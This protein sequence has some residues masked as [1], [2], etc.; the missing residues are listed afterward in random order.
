MFAVNVEELGTRVNYLR[1]GKQ[2]V[3]GLDRNN[4]RLLSVCSQKRFREL[5]HSE[6]WRVA[7]G[8]SG[9]VVCVRMLFG[10]KRRHGRTNLPPHIQMRKDISR[11]SPPHIFIS[12]SYDPTQTMTH[13]C[14]FVSIP[15]IWHCMRTYQ[16][17]HHIHTCKIM[18]ESV[19]IREDILAAR[20]HRFR[21]SNLFQ[22]QTVLQPVRWV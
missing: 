8:L 13:F 10:K 6:A 17:F 3:V 21:R 7:R 11:F 16:W 18:F 12:G 19:Y 4:G 1:H 2:Y 9:W 5:W 15:V 22:W 14:L 20:T